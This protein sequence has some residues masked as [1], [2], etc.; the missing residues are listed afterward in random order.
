MKKM[1][2]VLLV[3]I[4]AASCLTVTVN[5]AT[6]DDKISP[7]VRSLIAENSAGGVVVEI[8]Y[9]NPNYPTEGVSEEEAVANTLAAQRELRE[10]IEEIT[11]CEPSNL[12][13]YNGTMLIGLPYSS[14]E[15]VTAIENIDYIDLPHGEGSDLSAEQKMDDRLKTALEKLPAD[16]EV[17]LC[18]WFAYNEHAYIGMEEPGEN[19]TL[20]EAR[21]YKRVKYAAMKAYITPKN[22]VFSEAIKSVAE[23]EAITSMNTTPMVL[24]NTKLSEA[25]KIA[26]LREVASVSYDSVICIPCDDPHSLEDKF[27]K[28]VF[29]EA[30]F[31]KP[32][33]LLEELGLQSFSH[34]TYNEYREVYKTDDW[35]LVYATNPICDPWEVVGHICIGDRVLSWYMPGAAY[36][37]YGYFV[38][39]AEEDTFHPIE[40]F[41]YSVLGV[42]VDEDGKPTY[43]IL[44]PMISLEDYPGLVEAL[45]ACHIGALRGD[46]DGDGK[47]TVI[48]ATVIQR[49]KAELI[50]ETGLDMAASD[51][52]GDGKTTV[53]DATRVQRDLAGLQ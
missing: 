33:P 1:I 50:A 41:A 32:E 49:Y 3:V 16:T 26:S 21:E 28:W 36:F 6:A 29:E 25:E 40:R 37:P 10:A 34:L 51:A 52:D 22:A 18:V 31:V 48:D 30:G 8:T 11:Y 35:A 7:E 24:L 43:Q 12:I 2:S 45:D 27:A 9:H 42:E 38:Y 23:V 14:I 44:D 13:F 20:E 17:H 15:A 47:T 46:A 53:L 4:L 19:C 5:A 39:N